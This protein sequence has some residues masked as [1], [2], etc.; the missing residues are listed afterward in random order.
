ML[1][2]NRATLKVVTKRERSFRI[3]LDDV[4]VTIWTDPDTTHTMRVGY[5]D[6]EDLEE[7]I[8]KIKTNA[9]I[10]SV[11]IITTEGIE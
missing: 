7:T 1:C 5:S 3:D 6:L 9:D 10:E 8:A 11:E 4:E 2:I